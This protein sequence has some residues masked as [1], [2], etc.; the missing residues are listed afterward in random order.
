MPRQ[1]RLILPGIAAHLIQRG[2]NRADCFRCD[3]DYLVYLLHLK[4]LAAKLDCALHAY[5]LMTN[6]VH[7]LLTPP[8]AG[9]CA[10][11]MREL[12][13]R[14][15]QYFNRRHHRTGT[16]WEGRF[17]SSV[18]GTSDY[19]LACHCY[20]ELNPVRAAMVTSPDAYRWSSHAG[21]TGMRNDSLLG[22]H[23]DYVALGGPHEYARLFAEGLSPT[24]LAKIREAVHGGYPLGDDAFR[25]SLGPIE[26]RRIRPGKAGR[27]ARKSG[28]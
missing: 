10:A 2:N 17:H 3:S 12:G 28:G 11:L 14:Y 24:M 23:V 4:E 7:L 15:V 25:E 8:S 1:R 27:P 19:V 9:A 13:Q 18:I 21:N 26:P 5:C 20:I 16:L 6:H 22:R